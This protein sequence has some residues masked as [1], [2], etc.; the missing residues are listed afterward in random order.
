M[1]RPCW[2][3]VRA[4]RNR[5]TILIGGVG[6][7]ITTEDSRQLRKKLIAAELEADRHP[8]RTHEPSAPR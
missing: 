6:V 5:V 1:S 4:E 3:E 7:S 2:P 8:R